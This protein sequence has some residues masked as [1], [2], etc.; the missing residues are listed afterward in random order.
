MLRYPEASGTDR[1]P[2]QV[3]RRVPLK[4][5]VNAMTTVCYVRA[6]FTVRILHPPN[7]CNPVARALNAPPSAL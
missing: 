6:R 1:V 2:S 5:P 7:H 3:L 4:R